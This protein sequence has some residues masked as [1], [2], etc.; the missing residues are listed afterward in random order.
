MSL[1]DSFYKLKTSIVGT[2]TVDIDTKLD[3]AVRDIILYKSQS[4]RNG[5][6]DLLRS[7]IN[8]SNVGIDQNN[9]YSQGATSPEA[10]GH[11]GRINRY[12]TYSAIVGTINYCHR[13]L[14]VLVDNILAPDDITKVSL[15]IKPLTFLE[16]EVNVESEEKRVKDLILKTKLEEKLHV[17]VRNTLQYGDFFCEIADSK[18]ALTSR[19]IISESYT[20]QYE[21]EMKTGIREIVPTGNGNPNII[22]DYSS[23]YEAQTDKKQDLD[24]DEDDEFDISHIDINLVFHEPFRV[25]KLQSDMFPVCF[26]YLIFPRAASLAAGVNYQDQAVNSICA[27]ILRNLEGKIPGIKDLTGEN[28]TELKSIITDLL[29]TTGNIGNAIK[30]RYVAPDKIQHFMIPSTKYY[31]YG[32]SI[33]DSMQYTAKVLIALETALAI[34]RLSRSTEKRKIGVEIGLP[35]DARKMIEKMKEEF[36]KRKVSLDTF[37][38]VDT[39]PSMITTFEDI[40]IPQK[41]GK[42]FV[43]IDTFTAGNVDIRSKIDELKFLRDQLVA[44]LGVPPAFIGIEENSVVKATLTEENVL[45]ARTI[46][47]HQKYF[48]HQI[49]DLLEKIINIINPEASLS[50]LNNLQVSLPIPR[51]LQFEREAKYMNDIAT[52]IDNLERI[53]IPKEYAKKKYIH[54]IDWAEV[55]KYKI[56]SAIDEKLGTDKEDDAAAGGFG[57]LGGG[58]GGF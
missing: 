1:K 57:G 2:K 21:H 54:G 10:F 52:L 41:D 18:T 37:G 8:Q 58:G 20:A 47:S 31:P 38:T 26:G 15:E 44:S 13:A 55:E 49:N 53:G 24:N 29:K 23:L 56:E 48:T 33:F 11:G 22:M 50:L 27:S 17:I 3:K 7:I 35:R 6:I 40:Y 30:I 42:P 34:Q 14:A 4:G 12:K 51:S 43:D 32:E 19:A 28:K 16:D 9:F 45:F 46:I 5:Y 36:K 25:I 39:I